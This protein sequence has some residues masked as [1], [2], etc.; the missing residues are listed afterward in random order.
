MNLGQIN[1][2]QGLS[3]L[4]DWWYGTDQ[5]QKES[6]DLDAQL[7]KMNEEAK[8]KGTIDQATYDATVAHLATQ[9]KD[10]QN[11][12]AGVDQA[13]VDGAL[14][15][16]QSDLAVL[17]SIPKY[18]GKVSGDVLHAITTGVGSGL[19]SIVGGIPFW[20]WI[21]GGVALFVY[22]GGGKVVEHQARK[23][24]SRLGK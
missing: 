16:Y 8:A 17:N 7:Q 10:T 2:V 19:G 5:L 18:A 6:A 1:R 20:L 23:R 15:G 12:P 14:E 4:T 24:I 13:F 22:L 21:A 3:G 11:I 9:I